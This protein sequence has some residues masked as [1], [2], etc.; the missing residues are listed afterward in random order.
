MKVKLNFMKNSLYS[1]LVLTF[2]AV[3][4]ISFIFLALTLSAWFRT[5]YYKQKKQAM[6][7]QA[8][9]F[10]DLYEKLS[11]GSIKPEEFLSYLSSLDTYLNSKIWI[12]NQY[13]IVYGVSNS[14]E[15]GELLSTQI[16]NPDIDL[17]LKGNIVAGE[18]MFAERFN[19]PMY[20][21]MFPLVINNQI[22]GAAIM[23]TP[24][25]GIETE[26]Y[27][28]YSFIWL[29]ALIAVVVSTFIIYYFSQSILIKPLYE[30]NKTA[31]EI[32]DGEFEKR[33]NITSKDEIGQLAE[34]FNY[35]ADTLQNLE[36][37]RRDFIANISH[38]LRSPITTIR[39]FIQGILDGTI[40][41]DKHSYYL[42]IV[43]DESKRLTRLISDVLDLSRLESGEFS[44]RMGV[45]D[46]NELIRIIIIKFEKQIESKKL[47]VN[48]ILAGEFLYAYGDKDRIGQV[49]TNLLDNAIKFTGE[50]GKISVSTKIE[51]KKVIVSVGDSGP[52]IPE[53]ELKLI[54]DRFHMVDKSR[55]KKKGTG[56]GL[57]IARQ[58][59]NQHNEKIWVE[60]KEGVGSTF[61]FTLKAEQNI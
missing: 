27:R 60:S 35:M 42:S 9:V 55:T 61:S 28:I 7:S 59:I 36:N 48:V 44:L 10:I 52:G 24:M 56:L 33:V 14:K 3:I 37:M 29:A 4:L 38:E 47:N 39:G 8:P 54:W 16:S 41:K 23:S 31:R 58:I 18:G 15:D 5:Y 40:P 46:I 50:G 30:I 6:L 22:A 17:V 21:V 51:G 19:K 2:F 20:T 11:Y 32:S 49:I 1:K 25:T 13:K 26:L 45:F 53:D 43:L 57:S 34:S 12:I